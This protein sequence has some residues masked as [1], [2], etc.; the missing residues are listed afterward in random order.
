MD[1]GCKP[2]GFITAICMGR[3]NATYCL[4]MDL[5]IQTCGCTFFALELVLQTPFKAKEAALSSRGSPCLEMDE[6]C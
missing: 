3:Q 2:F 6:T 4:E 5:C 1:F